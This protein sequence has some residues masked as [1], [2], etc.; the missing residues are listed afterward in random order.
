M[1]GSNFVA[2]R[3]AA[4]AAAAALSAGC[5]GGDAPSVELDS[6][7]L[8]EVKVRTPLVDDDGWPMPADPPP[9]YRRPPGGAD[10]ASTR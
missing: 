3:L 8:S 7:T 5:G 2:C 6:S 4:I 10:E 9:P 1:S